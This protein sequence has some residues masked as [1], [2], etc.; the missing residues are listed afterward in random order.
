MMIQDSSNQTPA[1]AI[2][3]APLEHLLDVID[4][5]DMQSF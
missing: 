5:H 4:E 2:R 3:F 1:H